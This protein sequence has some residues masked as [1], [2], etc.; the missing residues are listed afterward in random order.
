[1]HKIAYDY[2]EDLLRKVSVD[3]SGVLDTINGNLMELQSYKGEDE[4]ED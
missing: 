2:A 3:V 1:L 4:Y